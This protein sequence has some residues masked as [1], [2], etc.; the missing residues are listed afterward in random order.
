MGLDG[1]M[2]YV[3]DRIALTGEYGELRIFLGNRDFLIRGA[4]GLFE[5]VGWFMRGGLLML[6]LLM[7]LGVF[8]SG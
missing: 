4:K 5:C 6:L 1:L 3:V 8:E 2:G 7:Q